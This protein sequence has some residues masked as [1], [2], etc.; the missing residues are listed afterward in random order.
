MDTVYTIYFIINDKFI[1]LNILSYGLTQI[2]G[3]W[4]LFLVSADSSV[5]I[6]H[7]RGT[8]NKI[9]QHQIKTVHLK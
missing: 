5:N 4:Y 1:T 2:P 8:M 3:T 6:N 9:I 7:E